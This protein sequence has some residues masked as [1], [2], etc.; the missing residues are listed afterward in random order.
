MKK[1]SKS[2]KQRLQNLGA[3]LQAKG[4]SQHSKTGPR[5]WLYEASGSLLIDGEGIDVFISVNVKTNR[6]EIASIWGGDHQFERKYGFV[7]N[8]NLLAGHHDDAISGL[9]QMLNDGVLEVRPDDLDDALAAP[10]PAGVT[11]DN[12]EVNN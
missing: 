12:T 1:L 5:Q 11:S 8:I 2:E 9:L 3:Q 6:V 4:L 10:A 7:F